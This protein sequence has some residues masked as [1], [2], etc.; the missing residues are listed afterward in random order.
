METVVHAVQHVAEVVHVVFM[1]AGVARLHAQQILIPRPRGLQPCLRV[2]PFPLVELLLNQPELAAL[3][4]LLGGDLLLELA[5]LLLHHGQLGL[6][7]SELGLVSVV[8]LHRSVKL[9]KHLENLLVDL[10][11]DLAA[12][13]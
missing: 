5:A 2:F 8:G 11:C 6:G 10:E 7:L 12:L 1:E 3:G 13:K 4:E 9:V